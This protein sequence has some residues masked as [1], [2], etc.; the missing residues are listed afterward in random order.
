MCLYTQLNDE[1][2]LFFDLHVSIIYFLNGYEFIDLIWEFFFFLFIPS[3]IFL[4]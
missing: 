4:S 3:E 2:I 1:L